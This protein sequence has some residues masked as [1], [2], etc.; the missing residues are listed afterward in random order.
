MGAYWYGVPYPAYYSPYLY[1]GYRYYPPAYYVWSEEDKNAYNNAPDDTNRTLIAMKYM[2]SDELEAYDKAMKKK[3]QPL[4]QCIQK[5]MQFNYNRA[6]Q[7]RIRS[8]YIEWD[9]REVL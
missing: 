6:I 4:P 2:T 7:Q 5:T 9:S 8:N 3:N 1:G